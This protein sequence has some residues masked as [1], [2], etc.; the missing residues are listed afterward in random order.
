MSDNSTRSWMTFIRSDWAVDQEY[1]IRRGAKVER[2][3]NC[4]P[5]WN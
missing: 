1:Y 5:K 2:E 4:V 3:L